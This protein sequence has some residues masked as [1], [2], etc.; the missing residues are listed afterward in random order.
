MKFYS[1]LTKKMYDTEESLKKAESELTETKEK[2]VLSMKAAAKRIETAEQKYREALDA[3][4][5]AEVKVQELIEETKA[6]IEIMLKEPIQSIKEAKEEHLAALIDFNKKC[7]PYTTSYSGE[8]ACKEYERL[9]KSNG[10]L[11]TILDSWSI[12]FIW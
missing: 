3:Y 7:G 12:P 6:Q 5:N 10:W 11:D 9:I 8:Q 2:N 4:D 1:E